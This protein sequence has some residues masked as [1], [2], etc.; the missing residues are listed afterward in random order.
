MRVF[1][2]HAHIYTRLKRRSIIPGPG[3]YNPA[4]LTVVGIHDTINT[5]VLQPKISLLYAYTCLRILLLLPLLRTRPF[6]LTTTVPRT[7]SGQCLFSPTA[8]AA[9][10]RFRPVSRRPTTGPHVLD[11]GAQTN[12]TYRSVVCPERLCGVDKRD[13]SQTRNT[14]GVC[15]KNVLDF[16]GN[17]YARTRNRNGHHG[18][19]RDPR[20]FVRATITFPTDI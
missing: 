20:R 15:R 14:S 17:V 8:A 2:G 7:A 12:R 4:E 3:R 16:A 5:P 9:A 11:S 1:W 6:P 10:P 13:F 19:Y 18:V